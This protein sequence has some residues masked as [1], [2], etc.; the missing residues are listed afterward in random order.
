MKKTQS[1]IGIKRWIFNQRQGPLVAGIFLLMNSVTLNAQYASGR[2]P[3]LGENTEM[4][5]GQELK[6]GQSVT[7]E[8]VRDPDYVNDPVLVDYVETIWQ[9]LR[10]TS[11]S[12]G[13]LNQELNDRFS[14]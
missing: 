7:R 4:T 2:L 3:S 8:I 11:L 12:K 13:Y 9:N 1:S 14:W 6:I 10:E 5:L